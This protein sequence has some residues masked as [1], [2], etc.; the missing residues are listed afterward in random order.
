MYGSYYFGVLGPGFLT[1]VPESNFGKMLGFACRVGFRIFCD[2]GRR[3]DVGH[4]S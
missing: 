1:Q 4:L 3:E 2:W